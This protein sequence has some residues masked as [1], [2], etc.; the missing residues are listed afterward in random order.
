MVMYVMM[1]VM[2]PI[3][4]WTMIG[5]IVQIVMMKPIGRATLVQHMDVC[6]TMI[7]RYQPSADP[8]PVIL[9]IIPL[10][11]HCTIAVMLIVTAV[12]AQMNIITIVA[13]VHKDV[14]SNYW[15]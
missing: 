1:V 10:A 12:T 9:I 4:M 13:R 8:M 5:V 14:S 11:T 2:F 15:P 7:V 3:I 6:I